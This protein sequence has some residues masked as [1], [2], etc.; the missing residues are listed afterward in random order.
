MDTTNVVAI[1]LF[2]LPGILAEKISYKIDFPSGRKRN[3]FIELIN[4]VALSFP[5]LFIVAIIVHFAY[6]L[7]ELPKYVTAMNNINFLFVFT[8][9]T[10]I[11]SVLVGIIA[12]LLKSPLTELINL[13]RVNCLHKM[14]TDSSSCW[15]KFLLSN[16]ESKFLEITING[17]PIKGFAKHYLLPDEEKSIVLETPDV[18]YYYDDYDPERLFTKVINTYVDIEKN[19]VI[20]D[21]D[22]SDYV[23]WCQSKAKK[24]KSIS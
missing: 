8:G 22:T 5:I 9:I 10:L 17:K 15:E 11:I 24:H 21:Y 3:D 7:N 2:I 4:G 6:D 1:L 23:A 19:I 14:K 16:N 20:K 13:V 12:G 18:L